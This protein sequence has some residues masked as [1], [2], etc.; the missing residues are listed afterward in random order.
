[1]A[2]RSQPEL[3]P[4]NAP[5]SK[6]SQPMDELAF[7][8]VELKTWYN[9]NLQ[10]MDQLSNTSYMLTLI[11]LHHKLLE[12]F[13]EVINTKKLAG[14]TVKSVAGSCFKNSMLTELKVSLT[15]LLNLLDTTYAEIFKHDVFLNIDNMKSA[16]LKLIS[17]ETQQPLK[18]NYQQLM[19]INFLILANSKSF[20]VFKKL[21]G[22]YNKEK[23]LEQENVYLKQ[24]IEKS[25]LNV[26]EYTL[27]SQEDSKLV[28]SPEFRIF[29][30][31]RLVDLHL[32][33]KR[34]FI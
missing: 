33:N 23:V 34:I 19:H 30:H 1:M 13:V 29:N 26:I 7:R 8:E 4:A 22:V 31:Q 14:F 27:L 28:N 10:L 17:P 32:F 6:P 21:N 9:L 12:A 3:V 20:S 11:H 18:S 15:N 25:H 5:L 2:H 16:Y 24:R